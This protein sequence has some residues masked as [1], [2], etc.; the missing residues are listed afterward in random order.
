M[1][2]PSRSGIIGFH[3]YIVISNPKLP[4]SRFLPVWLPDETL[5][6]L[7]IRYHRLSFHLKRFVSE[8]ELFGPLINHLLIDYHADIDYFERV[9]K[10]KLGLYYDIILNHTLLPYFS[11]FQDVGAREF[12]DSN[13]RVLEIARLKPHLGL[14][15]SRF[16]E[17]E[18]L[19]FCPTCY[20]EDN[21]HYG[22]A[23]W[24]RIHQCP[25]ILACPSHGDFLLYQKLRFQGRDEDISLLPA[26]ELQMTSLE[27]MSKKCNS[28]NIA[29]IVNIS[30]Y[31]IE[32]TVSCLE[33]P[34]E[35]VFNWYH[36]VR[37]YLREFNRRGWLEGD[38]RVLLHAVAPELFKSC[39]ML[40]NHPEFEG[41]P[42]SENSPQ[43]QLSDFLHSPCKAP[44]A[45]RHLLLIHFLF[46]TW[47][48]FI[49]AYEAEVAYRVPKQNKNNPEHDSVDYDP[50]RPL[51]MQTP[52][53][54]LVDFVQFTGKQ[55]KYDDL[56]TIK[57]W[58]ELDSTFIDKNSPGIYAR[59]KVVIDGFQA[60][61]TQREI[62]ALS[63]V[64]TTALE[65]ILLLEPKL[66]AQ[67]I[68]AVADREAGRFMS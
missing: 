33:Q 6:S 16:Q 18:V 42:V 60:G 8:V 61:L 15:R 12:T 29:S 44:Y 46:G 51:P 57:S 28:K 22:V 14:L 49:A 41:F 10:G 68:R 65:R 7:A 47:S 32:P 62:S 43:N 55:I 31:L 25:G 59:R 23:Y 27:W 20:G 37:V 38:G 9:T 13:K 54:W 50:S 58:T 26:P 67:W 5:F 36:L 24:H 4:R 17:N 64:S 40:G 11:P 3:K 63:G 53:N 48:S 35:L 19:K 45:L 66:H 21:K 1:A 34:L 2:H 56:N 52:D 30:K 39:V